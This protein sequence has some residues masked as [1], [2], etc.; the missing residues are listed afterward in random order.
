MSTPHLILPN[1][2]APLPA[3]IAYLR[4]KYP[5][6]TWDAHRNFGDTARFW[7]QMHDMFRELGGMLKTATHHFREGGMAPE[8]FHRFFAPRLRYFLGHLEGHHG[9]E[10]AQYFPLFRSYDKRLIVGFD[11][12]EEDHEYIHEQLILSA[13]TGQ[14]FIAAL[15][16]EGDARR[17]AADAYAESADR[18]LDWLLRHLADEEDLVMPTIIEHTETALFSR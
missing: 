7:M 13:Q 16:E 10:D 9:I 3:D 12:L 5:R 2:T 1:R 14:A 17:F 18:L 15:A 4:E 6:E 8:E 11:L